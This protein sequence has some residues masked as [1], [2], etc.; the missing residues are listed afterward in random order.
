MTKKHQE[1]ISREIRV[2]IQPSL[3]DQLQEKCDKEYKTI[4]EVIRDL[5]VQYVKKQL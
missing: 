5:V 3:Y 1:K 2:L 4:S